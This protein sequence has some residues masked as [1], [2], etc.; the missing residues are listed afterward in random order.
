[1]AYVETNDTE[2]H[3]IEYS[4]YGDK[5]YPSTVSI[6]YPKVGHAFRMARLFLGQCIVDLLGIIFII[7]CIFFYCTARY[8]QPDCETVCRGH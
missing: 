4:W 5:Q 8:S 3:T 2:V 1:M 6:P 7:W